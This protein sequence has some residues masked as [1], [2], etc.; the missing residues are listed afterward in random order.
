VGKKNVEVAYVTSLGGQIT[1]KS[2]S[3]DS[4]YKEVVA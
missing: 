1:R 2:V 3:Q 4:V